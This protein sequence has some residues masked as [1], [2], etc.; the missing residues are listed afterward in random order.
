[1]AVDAVDHAH[2]FFQAATLHA[3]LRIAVLREQPGNDALELSTPLL[4]RRSGT[5]GERDVLLAGAPEHGF[6]Q[7]GI[8]FFPRGF[9]HGA[10]FQAVFQ[11]QN[12]G[13]AAIDVPLP[14]TQ[15]PP[16]AHQLNAAL[17]ERFRRV[18][19]QT[20][21][22][23]TVD[24]A[25]AATVWAHALGAIKAEQLRTGRIETDLTIGTGIVGRKLEVVGEL[26]TL[27]VG[28]L[29]VGVLP[30]GVLPFDLVG[31]D[32][33]IA[34]AQF[35]GQFDRLGQPRADLAVD[36]KPV[37]DNLDVVPHLA[38][39]AQIVAQPRHTAVNP[40]ADEALFQKVFEE[41]AVLALLAADQRRQN[42]DLGPLGQGQN[43]LQNLF[44]G[45]GGDRLGALGTVP[46]AGAGIKH[47]KIIVN[48][49]DRAHRAAGAL[50]GRFLRDGDRR[51]QA[52]DQIDVGLGHLPQEL[53]GIAREAL[54][55]ASLPF[56][57]ERIERQ[58]AFPRTT[59]TGKANQL[60]AWQKQVDV[61][62]IMLSGT[63]N[64][65]VG[66]RH[67]VVRSR[68]ISSYG[69]SRIIAPGS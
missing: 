27:P 57:I 6:L 44:L 20:P 69:E 2:V 50:P 38:V 43:L 42:Q 52:G 68:R 61:A 21:R 8:Q 67:K 29:P 59:H 53:S 23:E 25:Q 31:G 55:I 17:L 66:G 49:G 10:R 28:V 13:H 65:Y 45:L 63:L 35:Q 9:Q 46:R 33:Q 18:G 37:G 56:G 32:N 36:R 24:R 12:V 54:H 5:P 48:L 40:S 7:L 15:L 3:V 64:E 16:F 47:A 4:A 58:R 60:I 39:Q 1:M 19:N 41:V 11:F 14:A 30:V 34:V 22:V 51:A 26:L 62:K